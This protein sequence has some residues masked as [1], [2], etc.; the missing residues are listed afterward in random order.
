ML[1]RRGLIAG[2]GALP[3]AAAAVARP[4][5]AGADLMGPGMTRFNRFTLGEF[6]VT[7]LLTN[8][9]TQDNPQEIFGLDVPEADF[10][11]AAKA[12]H[13]PD[14]VAKTF[15][16][17]T[18]VNT[19]KELVL[20]DTGEEPIQIIRAL[21]QAGYF[22]EDVDRVILT[23][24]HSDHI[25][26]LSDEAGPTFPNARYVT[27]SLEWDAWDDTGDDAFDTFMMPLADLTTFAADGQEVTTGITAVE[28]FGHTMGHMAYMVESAGKALFIGGDFVLHH[29]WSLEHP[30]WPVIFDEDKEAAAQT[31]KRLLDMLATDGIPFVGYH[32]PWPGLGFVEK[33]KDGGFRYV[34]ATYQLLV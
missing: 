5:R 21:E 25:S 18:L 23:H 13:L 29:V 19:G 14:T 20:F 26:G 10:K 4:A 1:S 12:R 27:G 28:A 17:P 31:R 33:D 22:V 16:T 2:A 30:D 32:M 9:A 3:L 8:M 34:P 6:E 11:A 7:N 24:M 15:F